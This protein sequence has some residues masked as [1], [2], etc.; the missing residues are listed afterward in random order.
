MGASGS[1]ST[2]T[3]ALTA[4]AVA[5]ALIDSSTMKA[6]TT[7]SMRGSQSIVTVPPVNYE[8]PTHMDVPS[9]ITGEYVSSVVGDLISG[10]S[11]SYSLRKHQP[12]DA[13][14][15]NVAF[16]AIFTESTAKLEFKRLDERVALGLDSEVVDHQGIFVTVNG[17]H[18][19]SDRCIGV[20]L[21]VDESKLFVHGTV[22]DIHA[23]L[24]KWD[25]V[26]I[27]RGPGLPPFQP[28]SAVMNVSPYRLAFSTG[29]DPCAS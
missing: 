20:D 28:D 27:D 5:T 24:V 29:G 13:P 7:V 8:G 18:E 23:A 14:L 26:L 25:R 17:F 19:L 11:I 4:T 2:A 21:T 9:P 10:V 1:V 3:V 6:T 12:N 22:R 16:P 15:A